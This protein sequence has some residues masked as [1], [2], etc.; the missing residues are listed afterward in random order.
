[1][2]NLSVDSGGVRI[3]V[4]DF[5]G[6]GP[7]LV[8]LHGLTGTFLDWTLMAPLLTAQHHVVALDLRGHGDSGDGD[9]SWAD[10]LADVAAVAEVVGDDNP[11]VAGHSLGGM[12]AAMWGEAHPGCPGVVNLDGHG[13]MKRPDQF[14]GLD[15]TTTTQQ[16]HELDAWLTSSEEEFSGPL[17][18]AQVDDL[19]AQQRA[20]AAKAGVPEDV[21]LD[22]FRRSLRQE[23]DETWLRPDPGGFGREIIAACERVDLLDLYERV[24]CP[25]LIF[26]ATTPF[27]VPIPAWAKEILV[28]Y[29]TGLTRDLARLADKQ[30]NVHVTSIDASHSL[31]VERPQVIADAIINFLTT[32]LS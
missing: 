16:Q 13:G 6:E 2:R 23:N 20:L 26:I 14:V 24:H 28:A 31:I 3:A 27:W 9:W 18:P 30:P 10:A 1:M 17:Q 7:A 21:I 15:P 19:L 29:R 4:R 8:L 22:S 11:A 5:G 32:P 25:L 12:L